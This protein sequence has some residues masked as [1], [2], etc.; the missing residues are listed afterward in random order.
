MRPVRQFRGGEAAVSDAVS[1]EHDIRG[2]LRLPG[3]RGSDAAAVALGFYAHNRIYAA[4]EQGV[5]LRAR[6]TDGR[7][8]GDARATVTVTGEPFE[9]L[10]ALAGRRSAAQL[11][12]LAWTGDADPACR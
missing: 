2:A 10:R 12:K 11:R 5:S 4:A 9:L 7:E 8:F 3:A 1:H 6:V